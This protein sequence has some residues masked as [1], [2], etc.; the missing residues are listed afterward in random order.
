M[1]VSSIKKG[2]AMNHM[3]E[4][5]SDSSDIQSEIGISF[6][7]E[8]RALVVVAH[9]DDETLW[10]GG[11]MLLYP[12]WKCRVACLSRGKDRDRRKKFFAAMTRLGAMGSIGEMDDEP[13]QYPIDNEYVREIILN[14]LETTNFDL[15]ITHSPFGEYTRHLRHEEVG[16][17]M[18]QLWER[19]ELTTKELWMF[20]YTD[21]QRTHHPQA[22]ENAHLE[23]SLPEDIWKEK[24]AIIR[25]VYGFASDS[26][27][28]LTT[29]RKEAFWR[30][31]KPGEAS[32][33]RRQHESKINCHTI[34]LGTRKEIK[35]ESA[36]PIRLPS[37]AGGAGHAG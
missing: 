5:R 21:S 31:R 35:N 17:A 11:T 6:E 18:L 24:L 16:R 36:C 15:I 8:L 10:M 2:V 28:V 7:S 3:N 22:I 25:D 37:L 34:S 29:P 26:W 13:D 33:W 30:F 9:P 12:D 23:V 27:E 4:S 1:K 20:A 19:C 32:T 14:E